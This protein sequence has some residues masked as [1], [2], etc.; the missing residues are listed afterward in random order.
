MLWLVDPFLTPWIIGLVVMGVLYIFKKDRKEK[1]KTFT[2][3]TVKEDNW[4]E[5]ML[6]NDPVYKEIN[7]TREEVNYY[8]NYIKAG[9]DFPPTRTNVDDLLVKQWERDTGRTFPRA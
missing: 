3:H 2:A 8:E 5:W 9:Y 7:D 6:E 1:P 4:H